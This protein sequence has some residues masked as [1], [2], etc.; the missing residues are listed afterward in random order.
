MMRFASV[1]TG[2]SSLKDFYFLDYT[3]ISSCLF[4]VRYYAV[5]LRQ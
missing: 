1:G 3:N 4:C 5:V 2:E